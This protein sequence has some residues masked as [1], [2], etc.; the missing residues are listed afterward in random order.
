MQAKW[1][2]ISSSIVFILIGFI[3]WNPST[4]EDHETSTRDLDAASMQSRQQDDH[5]SS[6]AIASLP[7]H[8]ISQQMPL[9]STR[10]SFSRATHPTRS[11]DQVSD[12]LTNESHSQNRGHSSKFVKSSVA[13]I[14]TSVQALQSS[15]SAPGMVSGG[16]QFG[17]G[18]LSSSDQEPTIREIV[19]NVPEGAKVPTVFYDNSEKPLPQQKALDRIAEE[20]EK[21]VSEVPPGLTQQEVWETARSIADERYITLFGYQAFNQYHLKAAKEALKEKQAR[22]NATRP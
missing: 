6:S 14:G 12:P 8:S 5:F 11:P 7:K 16:S 21:N 19:Q 22:F 20:F 1:I 10:P 9:S 13:A 2:F 15:K 4:V 18:L 3:F 17:R